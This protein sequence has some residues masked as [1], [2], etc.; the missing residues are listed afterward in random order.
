[1]RKAAAKKNDA[2]D[3]PDADHV[4]V[5]NFLRPIESLCEGEGSPDEKQE[6]ADQ[7]CQKLTVHTRIEEAIFY[8]Q[9]RET[10]DVDDL[11]DEA[12]VEQAGAKDLIAQISDMDPDDDNYEAKVTVLDEYI[13][14]Q[15]EE[16]REEMF[17]KA[18]KTKLDLVRMAPLQSDRELKIIFR[19]Q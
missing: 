6:L 1:M 8:P 5:K 18:R 17:V 11:L 4:A 16:E 10:I 12:E 7:I 2:V 13:D 19:F 9:V 15:V 14:H 3:L